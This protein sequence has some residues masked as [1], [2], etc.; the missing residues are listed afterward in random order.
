MEAEATYHHIGRVS[1]LLRAESAKEKVE[2]KAGG[3]LY[4]AMMMLRGD[5]HHI[6]IVLLLLQAH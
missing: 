2:K 5:F 1:P 6:G 3:M 4:Y